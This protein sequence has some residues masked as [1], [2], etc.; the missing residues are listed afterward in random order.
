M[1]DYSFII[2]LALAVIVFLFFNLHRDKRPRSHFIGDR[3]WSR[4]ARYMFVDGVVLIMALISIFILMRIIR[5]T[6][7]HWILRT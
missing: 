5:W 6:W 4:Q 2:A 1:T 3:S 7:I